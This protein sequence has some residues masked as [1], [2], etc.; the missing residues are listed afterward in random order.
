MTRYREGSKRTGQKAVTQSAS[1]G[2]GALLIWGAVLLLGIAAVTLRFFYLQVIDGPR[3]KA[4]AESQRLRQIETPA[5]RGAVYDRN[6]RELAK[7]VQVYTVT[8]DPRNVEIFY[9]EYLERRMEKREAPKQT[10]DGLR[11]ELASYLAPYLEVEAEE[12]AALYRKQSDDGRLSRYALLAK[13]IDPDIRS[14]VQADA[15]FGSDE[16]PEIRLFKRSLQNVTWE[17]DYKRVYPQGNIGAQVIGFTNA[18]GFGAAGIELFYED[19]LRG[20]P[21]VSFTER[22]QAGN[23]IPAG[24]QKTIEARK[25]S[26]IMLTINSEMQY[27]V[28]KELKKVVKDHNAESANALVM[29]PKTGEIY[30]AASYPF[31]D[32]NS[33]NTADQGEIRNRALVDLFEQGSTFKCITLAA[34]LDSGKVTAKTSFNV[35]YSIQVG[36]R[37]IK[38]SEDHPPQRLNVSQIIEQSSNV[39]VTRIAQKMGKELFYSY[40]QEF[41]ITQRP[42]L[43]FPGSAHGYVLTPSRF[44]DVTLSNYSFGQGL[45]MTPVQLARAVAAIANKGELNTPFLLKDIPD[46]SEKLAQTPP[47]QIISETAAKETTRVLKRVMT[48]GTGKKIKVPGFTVAGKT[49]TAQKA[50]EGQA[51]YA[52][53]AYVSSFIGF[54]PADDPELLICVIVDEPK[55]SYYGAQVAGPAFSNIATFCV[56]NLELTPDAP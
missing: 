39:G 34:A 42:G 19:T 9:E 56:R 4:R 30:A 25:G 48:V 13:Q 36:T 50:R 41:G 40:L 33:Y 44:N 31:F 6:G 28:Q 12:L 11:A 26:D 16:S 35:P 22:D 32:A 23:V 49:G 5:Q 46:G 18:E 2:S 10:L 47:K 37:V 3:L 52:E 1:R 15:V 55:G 45:S 20:T 54:L 53:G 7:S 51:G 24:L 43:D 14:Q 38:D 21:G 17:L 29:N 8:V 27:I